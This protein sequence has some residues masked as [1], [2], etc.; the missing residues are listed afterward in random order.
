MTD[1]VF[2]GLKKQTHSAPSGLVVSHRK[3]R[4]CL[5]SSDCFLPDP[6]TWGKASFRINSKHKDD[7]MTHKLVWRPGSVVVPQDKSFVLRSARNTNKRLT[8]SVCGAT[9]Q[10][11]ENQS[12]MLVQTKGR[13]WDT[14]HP[15][16]LTR[17]TK[18]WLLNTYSTAEK[19]LPPQ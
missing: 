9:H 11:L 7:Q 17:T 1:K 19:H 8:G 18:S 16:P 14:R 4:L 3:A 2:S 5:T 12:V 10:E 13:G 6:S 15:Q